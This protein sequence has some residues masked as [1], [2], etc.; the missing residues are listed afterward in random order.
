[1]IEWAEK[2]PGGMARKLMKRMNAVLDKDGEKATKGADPPTC[3]KQYDHRVM[4]HQLSPTG[5]N[6]RNQRELSTLCV[7]L[8]H[9]A[10]GRHQQAADVV[11]ARIKSVEAANRDGNFSKAQFLELLPVNMEGLTTTDELKMQRNEAQLTQRNWTSSGD[12]WWPS[13]KGK[14]PDNYTWVP[15]N[16]GKDKKG[17]GDGKKGKD[18][19]GKS[20]EK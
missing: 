13:G 5:V 17:K 1:M 16:K 18:G 9:L 8:D 20:K 7:I 10:L 12:G 19:K 4:K 3:A 2:H 15:N 11:A 14:K 6:L